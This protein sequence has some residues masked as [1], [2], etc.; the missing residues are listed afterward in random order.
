M[1]KLEY[2]IEIK[3][4]PARVWKLMLDQQTY[5]EWTKVSWP[6][7]DY[8]GKW[9]KGEDIQFIGADG[10]G[11]LAHID[12]F[13]PEK[14]MSATHVAALL[15][16]GVQDRDSEIAK[17]WVGTTEQ[18]TLSAAGN[19]TTLTVEIGAKP[20]WEEMFDAGW[21]AALKKIKEICEEK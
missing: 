15:P 14:K 8:K 6:G 21:P 2:S 17:G 20:G 3:S 13:V 11:T 7:S 5:K 9:A 1:K 19:T 16:G 18:Y 10:S 12:E 4:S